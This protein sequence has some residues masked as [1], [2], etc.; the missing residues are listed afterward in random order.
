MPPPPNL[1][2][3]LETRVYHGMIEPESRLLRAFIAAHGAEYDA[4]VFEERVGPGVMLGE[5]IPEK[6]RRNWERRTK[7]RPDCVAVTAPDRA[8]LIEVKEQAT[9]EAMW[10]VITYAELYAP[11]HPSHQVR[12]ALVAAGATPGARAIAGMRGVALF[13]YALNAAAPL[14]PGQETTA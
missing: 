10:Q 14:A 1:A 13:L 4:F 6:D 3:L 2:E 8:L 12:C 11:E 7:A 9:L 5:H